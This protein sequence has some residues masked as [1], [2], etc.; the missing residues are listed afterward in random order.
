MSV[1]IYVPADWLDLVPDE[2][3]VDEAPFKVSGR[4]IYC[5][6]TPGHGGRHYNREAKR[7]W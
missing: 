4:D 6:L 5:Q 1:L 7:F 3:C 2:L